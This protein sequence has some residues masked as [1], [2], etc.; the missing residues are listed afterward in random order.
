MP[1]LPS[2]LP[3]IEI[4]LHCSAKQPASASVIW[5]HGLGADGHD[6]APIVPELKL[7]AELAVRF[8][9]PHAPQIPVTINGGFVM[10]AWYDILE[11]NIDRKID[12]TQILESAQKITDLIDREIE[13]GVASERI[14]LAGFSQGGAVAY[15]AA[16]TYPKPLAGVLAMSTYF[17]TSA[18]IKQHDA[19]STLPIQIQHGSQDGVVP[20]ALGERALGSLVKMGYSPTYKSYAMEHQV[21]FEQIKDISS[22]LQSLLNR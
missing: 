1:D 21:C 14:V 2:L 8:V 18:T 5:L 17:A 9:F 11:M 7:P 10:P 19:N 13:L 22:W 16:L 6:F 4:E 12:E 15:Q 20:E 3:C